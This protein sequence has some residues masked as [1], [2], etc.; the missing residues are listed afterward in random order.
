MKQATKD[1][2]ILA[3]LATAPVWGILGIIFFYNLPSW[4]G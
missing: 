1:E 4:M 2:L 3:T